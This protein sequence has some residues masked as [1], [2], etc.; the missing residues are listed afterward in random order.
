MASPGVASVMM[1]AAQALLLQQGKATAVSSTSTS[2]QFSPRQGQ[3]PNP[4]ST[5]CVT[6]T[7]QAP[8]PMAEEGRRRTVSAEAELMETDDS[9]SPHVPQHSNSGASCA[10]AG[11]IPNTPTTGVTTGD[12]ASSDALDALAALASATS[13][14]RNASVDEEDDDEE[15]DGYHEEERRDTLSP[16]I[17]SRSPSPE[18]ARSSTS[19]SVSSSSRPRAMM[20]RLRSVSNPEGMEKWDS[21]GS[22]GHGAN[23]HRRHFVLPTSILEEELADAQMAV[24][25]GLGRRYRASCSSS[26]QFGEHDPHH[27]PYADDEPDYMDAAPLRISPEVSAETTMEETDEYEEDDDEE[28]SGDEEEETSGDEK[29]NSDGDEDEENAEEEEE[30]EDTSN[31]TPNELLRRARARLLEDVSTAN[32]GPA[33]TSVASRGVLPLPH[34]LGKYK[35][36]STS[37]FLGVLSRSFIEGG[38]G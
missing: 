30:E 2:S 17:A 21:M 10:A 27:H 6:S 19:S 33:G 28:G 37:Q 1:D 24:E 12:F 15:E 35:N 32:G 3:Q 7:D 9:A 4:A 18:Q 22:H 5:S 25:R 16:L 29:A 20:G 34:S 14:V 36:V 8:P 11:T 31:L 13:E 23:P 38:L 26:G